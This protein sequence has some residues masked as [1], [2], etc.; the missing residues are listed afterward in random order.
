ML[1]GATEF[2]VWEATHASPG[3]GREV[4][5]VLTKG[6]GVALKDSLLKVHRHLAAAAPEGASADSAGG[7]ERP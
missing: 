7:K 4:T 3:S 5:A 1:N 6:E 2:S